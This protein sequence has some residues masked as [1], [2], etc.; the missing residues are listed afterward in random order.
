MALRPEQKEN[1]A[2]A[3]AQRGVTLSCPRCGDN[4][5]SVLD[6]YISNLLTADAGEVA[7]GG[8]VLPTIGVICN[9][10]GFLAEHS[11]SA[12]GLPPDL[13]NH[14]RGIARSEYKIQHDSRAASS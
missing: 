12:L 4:A 9:R 1:I 7:L 11:M 3:L 6:A 13:S 5:W 10:C 8:P 14:K 2:K